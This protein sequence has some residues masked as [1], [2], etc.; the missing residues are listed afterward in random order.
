MNRPCDCGA[1][2]VQSSAGLSVDRRSERGSNDAESVAALLAAGTT[3]SG[4]SV[5]ERT[6]ALT[7]VASS[8]VPPPIIGARAPRKTLSP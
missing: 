1:T 8:I 4:A 7:T 5:H 2:P 6:T 3:N